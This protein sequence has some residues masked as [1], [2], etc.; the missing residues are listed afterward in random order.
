MFEFSLLEKNE[1]LLYLLLYSIA[2][3][4]LLHSPLKVSAHVSR[5]KNVW[6]YCYHFKLKIGVIN[7]AHMQ[8][9]INEGSGAL[10]IEDGPLSWDT[11]GKSG[12]R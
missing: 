3:R 11:I 4:A 12:A 9:K 1:V 8:W 6:I 10:I 2:F 7:I 5:W